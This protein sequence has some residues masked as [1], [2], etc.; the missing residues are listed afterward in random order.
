MEAEDPA[1]TANAAAQRRQGSANEETLSTVVQHV[2]ELLKSCF[3]ISEVCL[4]TSS[5]PTWTT[6]FLALGYFARRPGIFT[7]MSAT[8]AAGKKDVSA[9]RLLMHLMIE[10]AMTTVAGDAACGGGRDRTLGTVSRT[11]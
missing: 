3:N 4:E 5:Y 7:W 10:S 6:T 11:S 1:K 8:L 9:D 2:K